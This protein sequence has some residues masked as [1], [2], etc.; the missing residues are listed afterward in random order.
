M[1]KYTIQINESYSRI[2]TIELEDEYDINDAIAEVRNDYYN[3]EIVL[4]TNDFD[5]VD[6]ETGEEVIFTSANILTKFAEDSRL[7]KQVYEKLCEEY[8]MKYDPAN[9]D[10]G[11]QL[12][13]TPD[14]GDDF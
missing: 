10:E 13:S 11:I 12:V 1:K 8:I 3:E 5:D 9:P 7:K 4:D 6:T 2:V 14:G